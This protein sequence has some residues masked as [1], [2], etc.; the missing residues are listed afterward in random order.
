MKYFFI[1]GVIKAIDFEYRKRIV[2]V[3]KNPHQGLTHEEAE[4]LRACYGI[5]TM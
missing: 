2:N 4:I 1:D 3:I 5:G